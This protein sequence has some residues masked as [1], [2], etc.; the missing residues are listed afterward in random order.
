MLFQFVVSVRRQAQTVQPAVHDA[1][2]QARDAGK[3]D[4][5]LRTQRREY[6]ESLLAFRPDVDGR[7][8]HVFWSKAK[9]LQFLDV[10]RPAIERS[11]ERGQF[12]MRALTISS[13]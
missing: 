5:P 3:A 10:W 7:F 12:P 9:G 4:A 13:M 6:F 8:L 2:I 11:A 1:V